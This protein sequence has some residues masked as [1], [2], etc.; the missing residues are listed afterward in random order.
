MSTM[1]PMAI[2]M[3]ESATT[4]ASTPNNFMPMKENSTASGNTLDIRAAVRRCITSSTTTIRATMIC[5]RT[6]FSSVSRVS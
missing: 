2:A 3:P 6:A 4:L 1:V 5:W